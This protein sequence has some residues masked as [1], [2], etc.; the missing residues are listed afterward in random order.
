MAGQ[1]H[2]WERM[3]GTGGLYMNIFGPENTDIGTLPSED[4]LRITEWEDS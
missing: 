2:H 4:C 1:R 3:M